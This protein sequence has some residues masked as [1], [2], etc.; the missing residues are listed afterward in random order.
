[1]KNR[2]VLSLLLLG[3]SIALKAQVG[4][5][6]INYSQ[7]YYKIAVAKTGL[8][9]LSESDLLA[10]GFPISSTDPRNIQ[11]F[12]RG[13]QQ[14]IYIEG[15]SDGIFHS[16]DYIEFYGKKNDGTLDT[17]LYSSGNQPHPY[18]NL[19]SDSTY[20]FLTVGTTV[21]KRASQ[22]FEN[23]STSI[24][25]EVS[26]TDDRLLILSNQYAF[27]YLENSYLSQT[28]FDQGEGWTGSEIRQ[29]QFQNYTVTAIQNGFPA[30]GLPT[31]DL[32]LVG[33]GSM[34]HVAEVSVGPSTGQ[35]RL[36]TSTNFAGFETKFI[37]ENLSWTDIASD[38]TLIVQVKAL[39]AGA[40]DRLSTSYIRV[41]YPQVFNNANAVEKNFYLAPNG[42]G[43]SYVEISNAQANQKLIDITDANN[44]VYIG[45]TFNT[46]LNA[47]VPNTSVSRK[48]LLTNNFITAPVIKKVGF[49][50]FSP[51]DYNFI[52]I[53]HP[54]LRK[55]TANYTDPVLAYASYRASSIGGGF[56]PLLV[57]IDELYNQFN[58]GEISPR[59]IFKFMQYLAATNLPEYLFIVGR[60]LDVSG[61]YHRNPSA[62]PIL[63]DFVPPAG[64][65]GSD[66]FY[67]AGLGGIPNVP[68]VPTGRISS[69]NAEQVASYFDK[70][71][72]ME[73]LP[74]NSLWRKDLLHL[75]GGINE[76]EPELFQ[77]FM[78][79]FESIAVQPYM[80]ASVTAVAKRSTDVAVTV[81]VAEYVN[82]GLSLVTFFGHSSSTTLDF[83]IG[84]VSDPIM[85]YD[86]KGKYPMFLIN[87]CNAGA[88]FSGREVFGEDWINTP[89][90]GAVG[91]IAH[92]YFGYS[93][94]LR[95]YTN[96][97]YEV[98]YGD[99]TFLKAGIGDIQQEVAKR[100]LATYSNSISSI[101]QVQ[102][103]VLL[104]DPAVKLFGAKKPD[105]EINDTSIFLESYDGNP[106]TAL[107]DSFALKIQIR[108][109][110]RAENDSV[111]VRVTRT[112]NDN[113]TSVKDSIYYNVYYRDDLI[114]NV[115]KDRTSGFGNNSFVVEIDP[116]GDIDELDETNNTAG[117]T[118]F[119][120]LN[121]TKHLYPY[122]FAIVNDPTVNLVF[123]N[124]NLVA[125]PR[126][127]LIEVD[128]IPT[129]D[130][131]FKKEFA[132]EG[133]GIKSQL[134]NLLST[135]SLAYYWRTKLAITV[136]GESEEWTLS[137]FTYINNGPTGWVQRH[138][139]QYLNNNTVGLIKDPEIPELRFVESTTPIDIHTYGDT[140]PAT[141]TDVSVKIGGA[142][143][144]LTRQGF[145]CRDN[146]INLIAFS[147][148]STVPYA[149]IPFT[150]R[151]SFGRICGREPNVINSFRWNE[152]ETGN[153]DDIFTWVD[154][155]PVGDSVVL[156]SVGNAGFSFWSANVKTKLGELGIAA[157]QLS[158]LLDGE[159]VVIY[160]KKGTAPG[161]ALLFKASNTPLPAQEL[162]V[163]KTITGRYT[164]GEMY[165]PIIGPASS[166]QQLLIEVDKDATD[167][168]AFDVVGVSLKGEQTVLLTNVTATTDL[169]FVDPITFPTLKLVFKTEDLINLKATQ[170]KKWLVTYTPV[171]EGVLSFD[172]TR[173]TIFLQEGET[174]VGE[175]SFTNIS[176]MSFPDSLTVSK[177]VYNQTSRLA[178]GTNEKIKSPAPGATT[179]FSFE[180]NTTAMVGTN[181][182][183]VF[184]NP[185]IVPEQY[186]EN[187]V[188]ELTNYLSVQSD[189]FMPVLDVSFDGRQLQN[190]DVVSANP[191]IEIKIW[192][193]NRNLVKKDTVGVALFLG[194]PCVDGT[195]EYTRISFSDPSIRWEAATSFS[196]FR[197]QYAPENL[198]AGTYGLRVKVTD[199]SGNASSE[200]DYEVSF[201]VQ[202]ES[203]TVFSPVYPNPSTANFFF[204]IIIKGD[205]NPGVLNLQIMSMDGKLVQNL[206]TPT[207]LHVGTNE[208]IWDGKNA[209]G[210]FVPAGIYVYQMK[211]QTASGL[212]VHQGKLVIQH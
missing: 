132:I 75:S 14:A 158:S 23:N 91:F 32:L 50:Q 18:H 179:S 21:G 92:S 46:T 12:H 49:R 115:L 29:N 87:G 205:E 156:Y 47:V 186:Y 197:I 52:I 150:W 15:Q 118:L 31:V 142:E 172:G 146:T 176:G 57:N 147:K 13:I 71:K 60:G 206:Q 65:P 112:F 105:Y 22:F 166:W 38:G 3:F 41:Q 17:E 24:P 73:A 153:G 130:S 20:Y 161:T 81:N 164:D 126:E 178:I 4:N 120:P 129:F 88:F 55:P 63:K 163:N 165:S 11:L 96:K 204:T 127:F 149:G 128:T 145:I 7:D 193:Q 90:K 44:P 168:F 27:G 141:N 124:T 100:Y 77:Q 37:T 61:N 58:Y 103:M 8:Y 212:V 155:I 159:P 189:Y 202:S 134:V 36:L 99:S 34:A 82:K 201:I 25:A 199:A 19:F 10:A 211:L 33:R 104:G 101:T 84:F 9:R 173:E 107:A 196:D 108:N 152:L 174:W 182:V 95:A 76:G 109:F 102:Q 114:F 123:Q 35:L 106:I 119:I 138:F 131:P 6:W 110:G 195:C 185:R 2:F 133:S 194:F 139:P 143:F 83:D 45:T 192:D 86:N 54:E 68:G 210:G 151:N 181:D 121:S 148:S 93:N 42:G 140:H 157:S 183:N 94:T 209:S 175:Y 40:A 53:T 111:R 190:G 48:L 177:E 39:G 16:S 184:V 67:T 154:N 116:E 85:G 89:N 200:T 28:I 135:D 51:S 167:E 203:S 43:K 171:P 191:E 144:N 1:M 30:E 207:A 56:A 160:G 5:E 74:F 188:L 187:N 97:F 64:N 98:A 72:E 180:I 198:V 26:H 78:K 80:G 69:I 66:M 169:T 137:S 170:L 208:I 117:T 125:A 70:V 122:N 162:I 113:T 79:E 59:A 62:Y 136:P